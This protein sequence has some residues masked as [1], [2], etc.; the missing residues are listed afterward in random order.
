V[1]ALVRSLRLS[2]ESA[3]RRIDPRVPADQ[4]EVKIAL[5][6]LIELEDLMLSPGPVYCRGVVMASRIVAEGTG[7]LYAPRRRGELRDRVETA[8]AALR[9][10][11]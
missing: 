9:G 7:P 2:R 1:A 3:G 6:R 11:S 4:V 5:P 8:L 10:A